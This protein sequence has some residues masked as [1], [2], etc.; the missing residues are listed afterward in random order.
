MEIK[1]LNIKNIVI[2][3]T[4]ISIG[5]TCLGLNKRDTES[6]KISLLYSSESNDIKN[7]ID[8]KLLIKNDDNIS[9]YIYSSKKKDIQFSLV[10]DHKTYSL[11]IIEDGIKSKTISLGNKKTKLGANEFCVRYYLVD[12]SDIEG[13][14]QTIFFT[15]KYGLLISEFTSGRYELIKNIDRGNIH[16]K[17]I[18]NVKTDSLFMSLDKDY[19]Y[20]NLP[21]EVKNE[22]Q[23]YNSDFYPVLDSLL[24]KTH[25]T[26]IVSKTKPVYKIHPYYVKYPETVRD[27]EYPTPPPPPTTKVIY[28][29][30]FFKELVDNKILTID[31]SIFIYSSMDS[32]LSIK[33]NNKRLSA[34]LITREKLDSIF[35]HSSYNGW[36]TIEKQYNSSHYSTVSTPIFNEDKTKMIIT[37]E[38][39][40]GP[41]CGK[42][43]LYVFA[44]RL[45]IWE[46]VY[47]KLI[48]IS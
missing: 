9:T 31:E 34:N 26:L 46:E 48:W 5:L 28:N 12:N 24:K 29:K 8:Y 3:L 45:D 13:E 32:T 37:V 47:S 18:E 10:F 11:S 44:K 7:K 22:I 6:H 38:F 4:F 33:L 30:G 14:T 36:D 20:N 23:I 39:D 1:R 2:T 19:F 15:E 43:F 21:N 41:L 17:I 35:N 27:K 42:G 40:C 25:I 16:E